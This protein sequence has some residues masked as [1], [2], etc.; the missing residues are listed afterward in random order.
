MGFELERFL[1]KTEDMVRRHVL[2][3]GAGELRRRKVQRTVGEVLRRL[4]RAGFLLAGLLAGLVVAS[5]VAGPL[6]LLTWLVAIPTAFLLAF[7]S[8][9]LPG[10]ARPDRTFAGPAKPGANLAELAG[11]AADGLLDRSD[12]L[13]AR[14]LPAADA[15][16]ARLNEVQPHLDALPPESLPAGEARRLICEHLPR[17]VDAY[18]ALPAPARAPGSESSLRFAESLD[19]LAGE[20]DDLLERCC[21]DRELGFET[22]RRFIEA[23]YKADG[24]LRGD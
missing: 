12:E 5:I 1:Y 17:L 13:P 20:F 9:F 3:P 11:R 16:V 8:L 19:I 2:R 18:L 6:G 21:R 15:I 4:R 23:R 24:R 7:L 10:R 14:A 22:Q